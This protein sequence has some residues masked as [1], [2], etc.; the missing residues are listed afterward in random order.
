MEK[1]TK[2]QRRKFSIGAII[3][4][5]VMCAIMVFE[6][7]VPYTFNNAFVM[8]PLLLSMIIGF[9]YLLGLLIDFPNTY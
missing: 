8:I 6:I 7:Y 9:Y 4:I 5:V 2:K 3:S 1:L